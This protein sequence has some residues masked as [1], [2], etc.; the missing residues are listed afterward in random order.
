MAYSNVRYT[1]TRHSPK[2]ITPIQAKAV[3][4]PIQ[5]LQPKQAIQPYYP[6]RGLDEKRRAYERA[7]QDSQ[8]RTFL[9]NYNDPTELNSYID[10]LVNREAV[11]KK[12]GDAWGTISTTSGTVAVLS[13]VAAILVEA[14][15]LIAAPFTGGASIAAVQPAAAAL[16]K[17]GAVTS[18]PAIPAAVD[19]TYNTGIKPILAGKPKEAGLN[20]LMNL[21]E[22]MDF[23]AN[24]VKG[25]V[26][27]GGEGFV[28][29]LGVSSK[30][31]VNYDYDTGFFLTD[32]LLEIISDPTNW[33]SFGTAGGIKSAAKSLGK[34]ATENITKEAV[35]IINKQF[36]QTLG[37]ISQEGA[38]RVAKQV[39]DTAADVAK[40]WTEKSFTKMSKEVQEQLVKQGQQRIQTSLV[41]AIKK[42]LPKA[43]ASNITTIL[44]KVNRSFR[45][46]RY[47]RTI[48]NQISDIGFDKLTV[49][50]LKGLSG[51]RYY[52]DTFE[53]F[54][55]KGALRSSGFGLGIDAA[56]KGFSDLRTWM[57]ERTLTKLVQASVFDKNIGLDIK[58]WE[59]AKNIWIETGKQ[60][61]AI[62]GEVVERN[63]DTFYAFAN[64][65][66]NR[67]AQL[68]R[69]IQKQY[70]NDPIKIAAALDAR[71]T[72]MYGV[73]YKEYIGYLKGI[74]ELEQGAFVDFVNYAEAINSVLSRNAV[75]AQMGA[76]L[77]TGAQLW[78]ASNIDD[79]QKVQMKAFD[80]LYKQ[81]T[82]NKNSIDVLKK[83]Y[84]LKLNDYAVNSALLSDP[85]IAML[86]YRISSSED[87]G[88]LLNNI[89]SDV[90]SL[91]LENSAI[92]PVAVR[93]IKEAG[94]AFMN[95]QDLYDNI[96][97]AVFPKIEGIADLDFKRYV[98]DQIF[99]MHQSSVTELLAGF[100]EITMPNLMHNLEVFLAD[101]G[102][103]INDYPG[104]REQIA[105]VYRAFLEAQQRAGIDTVNAAIVQDFTKSVQDLINALPDY[106]DELTELAQA[107]IRIQ[108]ALTLVREQNETFLHSMLLDSKTIFEE[109]NT[110][111]LSDMG[112]ALK[113][114][115]IKENI[116]LFNLP[117]N[118]SGA[119][120][121][122]A[123]QL[124]KSINSLKNKF[125]QYSVYFT[126]ARTEDINYAY[127][128]FR[129][130]FVDNTEVILPNK[131]FHYLKDTDD[132][133][134]QF[135]Q[136]VEFNK[137]I[138][139]DKVLKR[140]FYQIIP[141]TSLM[142]DIVYPQ[143]LLKTDFAWDAMAQ[144]AWVAE[145][146]FNETLINSITAYNKLGLYSKK[147]TNDFAALRDML[148]TNKLDRP[149]MLQ[150]ERYIKIANKYNKV[151]EYVKEVYDS[152]FDRTVAQQRI[153][154]L[155]NIFLYFPELE[156]RYGEL[157]NTLDDYWHGIKTFQQSP[158]SMRYQ[159]GFV[160][161]FTPFWEQVKVM[162]KDIKA[163]LSANADF[164]KENGLTFINTTPWDP[165]KQQQEFNKRV[166]LATNRNAQKILSHTF[167]YTPDQFAQELA[168]RHRF[169]TFKD[170]DIAEGV[171]RKRF[172]K[173]QKSVSTDERIVYVYDK[174]KH[175]HWFALGKDEIVNA[176]GRQ[177]YLN[178]NPIA[179]LNRAN[180]FD[181]F[182]IVDGFLNDSK[183]P[184][185]TK[186]LNELDTDMKELIGSSLGDSHGE[187]LNKKSLEQMFELAEDGKPKNVPQEIW[188][189]MPKVDGKVVFDKQFFDA[190]Q[191]NES[192]L[193]TI[194]SKAELGVYAGN[195]ITNLN[196]TISQ[197]QA[198]LKPKVEYVASVF[199][200]QF[201]IG[202][203][204]GIYAGF[205]NEDLLAA[206]Q[207]NPD[208]KLIALV[209]DAKYGVK[210]HEILP[211]SVKAIQKA[212]ELG[213]VIVPLQTYK[214]MYNVV[215]HRLG[216]SGMA[217]L[218][219]RIMYVYKFGY[220]LRP[221]AWIRNWF[222]TN[223]KSKLEMGDEFSTYKNQA[224]KIIQER[225]H[226]HQ[227]LKSRDPE[228]MV[229]MKD[230]QQYFID[231]PNSL[232]SW[233]TYQDLELDFFSQG[234]SGNVMKQVIGD[235]AWATF[236]DMTGQI[237]S[238]A[239]K[240]ED[241]NRLAY[242][243][244]Q[245]DKGYDTTSALAKLSKT[246]FD[247]SFKTKPE[248][249]AEMFFP[250]T[251]FSMRNYSY[252]IEQVEKHPWIMRNYVHLMKPSWD[253]KDYTPEELARNYAAQNQILNGQ[254]KLAE[255]DNKILTFKA[256][257]SIQDA[258]NMATDPLT[259]IYEKLA[260][261]IAVPLKMTTDEY[262]QPENILP[263][264]GPM[265]S[266]GK[267][268]IEKGTP[269]PSAIGV[270]KKWKSFKPSVFKN[271][272]YK[273]MNNYRDKQYRVPRYRNNMIYDSYSVKGVKR[274][275]LNLYPIVDI[276]H[277]IKS[278]YSVNV[279]SKIKSRVET[280][281]F[282]G[283]RYRLKLDVNRFR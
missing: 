198:Y 238:V 229:R 273:G 84:T 33:V 178:G 226:I 206:L 27:E 44:Q 34:E 25:L 119:I 227:L 35:G 264:V 241:Y 144:S 82:K 71:F 223:I 253:F 22:T 246:H 180:Q 38:E 280:D 4:Q 183:N 75:A 100:D 2:L 263:V 215:N 235:D 249:L 94:A 181:E 116:E 168:F 278:R 220:L 69:E 57:N 191:F 9:S 213:A 10:A 98:I 232:L 138:N 156:Q 73:D 154:S 163:T 151:L 196:N 91:N 173:F 13:F 143:A 3:V 221:G 45:S 117:T 172:N 260:A 203:P 176:S 41:N 240:T 152:L 208:Y 124:G 28:K 49:G 130:R 270:Q 218:W 153:E 42:E 126:K 265:I 65:Q 23:A 120:M 108:K 5:E 43:S 275:R 129:T 214:D 107:N 12:F 106:A 204:K 90:N 255:F 161:E 194:Q 169:I 114:I 171:I 55:M 29:G 112:L 70:K 115:A 19:V 256:N 68:I 164:A 78:G 6:Y 175:R 166:N 186:A 99:G 189:T 102:F 103:N 252:W 125:K 247:Y 14:G 24:P 149:L 184:G 109:F 195:M 113:T 128:Y 261:P 46:G 95:M 167:E 146:Q 147:M 236:T 81:A 111:Q 205:S 137:S 160:D 211:T 193:G 233:E 135:A 210:T 110:R 87:I 39:T 174:E 54:M 230:V 72:E 155:R 86:L 185:I 89:L 131:V 17:V 224:T 231:N 8:T 58:N 30:G 237:L 219:N 274:Y 7:R 63:A 48:A 74:N 190:Y 248:Q 234:V 158:K 85:Q 202:N 104:V 61:S 197:A 83:V 225:D 239:N 53:R 272:N 52:S 37:E 105:E 177:Y 92:I 187:Y 11:S 276:A 21:G 267:Q 182:D 170:E 148:S 201:S 282:K 179:R 244:Y 127:A 259:A 212:R 217:K 199:D 16:A 277:E 15:G 192:I 266:S 145:K 242:Y 188:D 142:Q 76:K 250:F 283:I 268:M 122:Q 133:Y 31:R 40:E 96:A 77:S 245:L 157:V 132:I 88:A 139:G 47:M 93:T 64:Q 121:Q 281:V 1:R 271:N 165:I 20:T 118:V 141:D 251:T 134:E 222:D 254:I 50:V 262:V 36:A 159:E 26:M 67:D 32:V 279:Y 150:Q 123:D 200:S 243:L 80:K 66:F 140:E 101:K 207:L 257:P 62:T 51:M 162:N 18:I 209:D 136:L 60:T 216:S 269:L 79:L 59:K 258:I 97:K 228:G 56:K